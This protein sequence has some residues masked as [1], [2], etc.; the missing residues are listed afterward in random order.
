MSVGPRTLT[1]TNILVFRDNGRFPDKQRI[2]TEAL[3][4]CIASGSARIAH[5]SIVE[6]AA[7]TTRGGSESRLLDTAAARREA[8]EFMAQS[9]I[10]YSDASVLRMV[11]RGAA[12]YGLS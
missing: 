7:A 6:F 4:D 10:L 2:A 11:L 1:D 9:P 5:Q 12:A 3:R 8:E